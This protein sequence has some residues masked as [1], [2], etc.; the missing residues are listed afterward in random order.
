MKE[1]PQQGEL[2]RCT[3]QH[4]AA[5]SVRW[6]YLS[7][8]IGPLGYSTRNHWLAALDSQSCQQNEVGKT[9]ALKLLLDRGKHIKKT[10]NSSCNILKEVM[11]EFGLTRQYLRGQWN[12]QRQC[13]LSLMNNGLVK[14]LEEQEEE[15]VELE[16][17]LCESQ[18]R[19]NQ[20]TAEVRQLEEL[21]NTLIFLE[22]EIKS[23]VQDLGDDAG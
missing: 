1:A 12:R 2:D 8:L 7:P 4:T 18:R 20:T 11:E 17:Q 23:I 9:H 10:M 19:R 13:Q 22:E 3:E 15:L 14:E 6:S 16:D 21:P 5:N